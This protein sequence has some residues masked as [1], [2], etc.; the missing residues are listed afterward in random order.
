MIPFPVI[1]IPT[2]QLLSTVFFGFS[3]G[4]ILLHS[5]LKRPLAFSLLSGLIFYIVRFV[6][7]FFGVADYN[8]VSDNILSGGIMWTVYICSMLLGYFV[9]KARFGVVLST[10]E[11]TELPVEPLIDE[12][13]SNG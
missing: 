9:I 2:T 12:G 8:K 3:I 4:A 1:D 13:P 10:N 5:F 7:A 11:S 6:P